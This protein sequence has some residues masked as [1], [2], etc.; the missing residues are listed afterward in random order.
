MRK[1][2]DSRV[3]ASFAFAF[4]TGMRPEELIGLRW[5]DIDWRQATARVQ[6]VRT[7]KGSERDRCWKATLKRLGIR[8]RRSYC[9]RHTD[10]TAARMA[11]LKPA[12]I[13]SQAGHT[14]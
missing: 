6:R 2:H 5:E 1:H 9:T 12:Y 4:S 11:G 14:V 13:A 7:F 3:V 10:C 8:E